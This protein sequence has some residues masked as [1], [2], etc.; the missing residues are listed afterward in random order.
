MSETISTLFGKVDIVKDETNKSD[1]NIWKFV[2]S[3]S[4]DKNYLYDDETSNIYVPWIIN[5]SF[6]AHIDTLEQAEFLNANAHLDKKMQ[7]DYLFHTVTQKNKRWKP[8]LKKTETQKKDDKI[9]S[10]VANILNY[11]IIKTKQFWNILSVKQRKEF[12]LKYVYQDKKN[13]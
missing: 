1:F 13:D 12:L 3:I 5:K 2:S 9:L 6:S 7:H 8:W 10:D 4:T 11:N